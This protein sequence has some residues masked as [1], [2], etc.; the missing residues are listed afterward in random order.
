MDG[1]IHVH[2]PASENDVAI[3]EAEAAAEVERARIEA[4]T[5]A[6]AIE[7]SSEIHNH[8]SEDNERWTMMETRHLETH[9]MVQSLSETVAAMKG[10][11][12]TIAERL[13]KQEAISVSQ[14]PPE[15]HEVERVET[16]PAPEPEPAPLP[17]PDPV[18]RTKLRWI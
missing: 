9:G 14:Q 11:L 2:P 12:E 5:A 4:E 8:E 18:K 3:A 17:E 7:A 15:N 6:A 13:T 1:E 16:P 10:T